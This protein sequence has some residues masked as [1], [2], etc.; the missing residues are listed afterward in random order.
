MGEQR[1]TT[2]RT[3]LRRNTYM[4]RVDGTVISSCA[5][6]ST[7][8]VADAADAA[9]AAAAA[10]AAPVSFSSYKATYDIWFQVCARARRFYQPVTRDVA[11][12]G[13]RF[14]C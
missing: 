1:D 2:F 13:L 12:T 10:A 11:R 14:L 8:A 7:A 6:F 5:S 3:A 4:F 9:A